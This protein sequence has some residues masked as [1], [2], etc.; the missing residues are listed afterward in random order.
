MHVASGDLWAGAEVQACT[1]LKNLQLQPGVEVAAAI[2]N[3]GE[4]SLRLNAAGIRVWTF[5]ESRQSS[6][7]ITR[8]LY[9][10]MREWRPHIVHTH[11]QKENVLGGIVAA[12]LGIPSL[13]TA[14]GAEEHQVSWRKPHKRLAQLLDDRVATHLQRA[15]VAVSDDL[16]GILRAKWPG[17]R[18]EIVDNVVDVD[19]LRA[20]S[21]GGTPRPTTPP[22]RIGIVGR[23]VPIK[24]VDLFIAAAAL[25]NRQS[26]GSFCFDVIGDGPLMASLRAQAERAAATNIVFHGFRNDSAQQIASM[27]VLTLT[28]DHEGLPTVA[29]EALALGVPVVTRTVGG[30]PALAAAGGD[31]MLVDTA[32][33]QAIADAILANVTRASS[34]LPLP[35]RYAAS[36]GAQRYLDFYREIAM[37]GGHPELDTT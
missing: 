9:S 29:L 27:S 6:A 23:L 35:A 4:L 5:D 36:Y 15:V 28:S 21:A 14:H 34:S 37:T 17:T 32:E 33:P 2:L 8:G 16:A 31:C 3:P 11:R 12:L 20:Q 25:L 19:Q 22:W 26:P 30:L 1:L 10:A 7:S 24:R 13:R 18:I